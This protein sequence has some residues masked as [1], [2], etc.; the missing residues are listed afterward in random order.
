[1]GGIR[2]PSLILVV[3]IIAFL[4]TI[5]VT[6]A[7][8]SDSEEPGP[9]PSQA[10]AVVPTLV[11]QVQT[12]EPIATATPEPTAEPTEVVSND[13]SDCAEIQ[14][15]E[16]RSPTEREWYLANCT[17]GGGGGG[18]SL[19]PAQQAARPTSGDRLIIQR[20][21]I[22][23][24][25]GS[26]YVGPDGAMANPSG[27]YDVVWYDFSG[28]SGLGGYPGAGGNAVFAG[29][30]D[31]RGVGPAVFYQ[32]RNI[33]VGDII[34]YY[35]SSGEYYRYVVD[36]VGDYSPTANWTGLVASNREGVTLITCNGEFNTAA[37]EYS[38]RRV[39]Y[40]RPA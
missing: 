39:V 27:A 26:R 17:G 1:L 2:G 5:G 32:L 38:H 3:P 35:T 23:A 4:A 25:V 11:V 34:E 9:E 40:A 21:G 19:V 6:V 29:H 37:R 36:S 10:A 33:L 15:T 16:Y 13:R 28:F 24:P 30:V 12:A 7:F 22:N 14:G 31:Y 20:L 8:Q 18:G